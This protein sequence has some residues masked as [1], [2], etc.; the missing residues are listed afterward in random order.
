MK[1][2]VPEQMKKIAVYF[3]LDQHKP[4]FSIEA[5]MKK[6][7][8]HADKNDRPIIIDFIDKWLSGNYTELQMKENWNR[9][10]S[11]VFLEK[12][13][14]VRYFLTEFRKYLL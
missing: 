6:A 2:L 9:L 10:E 14:G 12:E 3:D 8:S 11:R 4:P 1:F 13:G 7:A 5:M